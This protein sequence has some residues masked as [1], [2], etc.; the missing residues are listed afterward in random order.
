MHHGFVA[1]GSKLDRFDGRPTFDFHKTTTT[2]VAIAVLFSM[3][4]GG[5]IYITNSQNAALLAEQKSFNSTVAKTLDR[6]DTQI[7]KLSA[8]STTISKGR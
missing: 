3:I 6:H 5:I 7:D 2:I 1:L 4:C 8:W